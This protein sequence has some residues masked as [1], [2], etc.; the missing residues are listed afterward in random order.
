MK[1]RDVFDATGLWEFDY[2]TKRTT[3][4]AELVAL[5]RVTLRDRGEVDALIS[6]L[7]QVDDRLV[8]PGSVELSARGRDRNTGSYYYHGERVLVAA[9][10]SAAVVVHELAHHATWTVTARRSYDRIR[11]HNIRDHGAEFTAWI[12]KFAMAG[13]ESL[14]IEDRVVV[15]RFD[16]E[17]VAA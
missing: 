10:P 17:E 16:L 5:H 3:A 1:S 8:F 7:V 11:E 15:A 2:V 14:A 9:Q 13:V 6:D 12:S 4:L